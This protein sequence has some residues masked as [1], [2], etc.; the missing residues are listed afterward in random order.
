MD[1]AMTAEKTYRE[2]IDSRQI[3]STERSTGLGGRWFGDQP[4]FLVK[5]EDCNSSQRGAEESVRFNDSGIGPCSDM[6]E[7]VREGESTHSQ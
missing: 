7:D 5:I 4:A 3:G 6:A 2:G 1:L